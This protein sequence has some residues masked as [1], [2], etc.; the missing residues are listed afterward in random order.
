MKCHAMKKQKVKTKHNIQD[1]NRYIHHF[2]TFF[3]ILM[4]LPAFIK[5]RCVTSLCSFCSDKAN[6]RL[7]QSQ[8]FNKTISS[9]L[10]NC[11]TFQCRTPFVIFQIC[12]H[13][14]ITSCAHPKIPL[15][16]LKERACILFFCHSDSHSHND[17]SNVYSLVLSKATG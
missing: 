10:K 13:Q 14:A 4:D 9:L 12:Y 2:V 15:K 5:L 8:R 11:L 6:S 16:Y 7:L 3:H 1:K 17:I